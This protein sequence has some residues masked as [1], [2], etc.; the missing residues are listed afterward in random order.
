MFFRKYKEEIKELEN[1]LSELQE[2]FD[3]FKDDVE[4][5]DYL[6]ATNFVSCI[7]DKNLLKELRSMKFDG[8]SFNE[9]KEQIKEFEFKNI[10][11]LVNTIMEFEN[12]QETLDE[13]RPIVINKKETKNKKVVK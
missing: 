1:D 11:E 3:K 2:E 8:Y 4:I 9:V 13:Y 5:R 7:K 12:K 10:D 6:I